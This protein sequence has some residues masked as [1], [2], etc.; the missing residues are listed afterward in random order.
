MK[1]LGQMSWVEFEEA[2][3]RTRVGL[4]PVGAVEVYGPHLPQGTDGIVAY[5]LCQLVCQRLGTVMTP[6]VPVGYSLPLASFAGTLT[7]SPEAIKA[8]CHGIGQSLFRSGIQYVLYVNSHAGNVSEI[9]QTCFAL[10][11]ECVGRCAQID[12]WR[13]IQPLS[14]SILEST[15]GMFGHAG[16]AMTSVMLYLHPDLVE[17]GRAIHGVPRFQ[18]AHMGLSF[19]FSYRDYLPDGL[20]GN[21]LI[22]TAEKGRKIVEATVE[23]MIG[24][25]QSE[26]F[27]GK[28]DLA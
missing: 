14:Q 24:F 26:G 22:G 3:A 9:N 28:L 20:H 4:I 18:V 10:E 6:L 15:E 21:A 1:D 27:A 8:Y 11:Q 19:P 13:F 12:V 2:G 5:D 25:I 23:A 17:M 16:E 7:V